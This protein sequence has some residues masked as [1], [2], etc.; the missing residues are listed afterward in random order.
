[1]TAV[2]AFV[3]DRLYTLSGAQEP[4]ALAG[5]LDRVAGFAVARVKP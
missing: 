2:P 4:A 1:L 5:V 3:F